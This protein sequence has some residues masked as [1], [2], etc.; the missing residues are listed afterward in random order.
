MIDY[1]EAEIIE[2]RTVSWFSCGA[3]S[4]VATKLTNPDI[5]AY[6][7][8]G[9]EDVDNARFMKDCIEWWGKEVTVLKNSKYQDT[10]QVFESRRYL[11]G[12]DGAPCTKALKIEPRLAFQQKGDV[13]IFGYTYD[14]RDRQ[15]A[16]TLRE[17]YP[18]LDI[19][20]PLIDK[21]LTKAAC[22][23]IIKQ[24][25]INPPRVYAL[26]FPN[27]NCIPCVKATSPKYWALV[28]KSYPIEFQRMAKLSRDLGVRLTRLKGERVFIDEI[29]DNYPTFGALAPECDFLCQIVEQDLEKG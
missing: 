24:A 15:R 23:H 7:H 6:C 26:G 16:D 9:S 14:N 12:I 27:A 29:P 17:H 21:K 22:L 28:R 8:T 10:W 19:R 5:I 3:A 18:E 11:S 1:T 13:H 20:T 4:A 2:T 25:S